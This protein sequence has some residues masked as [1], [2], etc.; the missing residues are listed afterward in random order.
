M[1]NVKK[2][3]T[4][5]DVE[6]YKHTPMNGFGTLYNYTIEWLYDQYV[7]K[8]NGRHAIEQFLLEWDEESREHWMEELEEKVVIEDE[9]L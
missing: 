2:L 6:K 5:R 4:L 1:K 9:I 3:K 8:V 7:A